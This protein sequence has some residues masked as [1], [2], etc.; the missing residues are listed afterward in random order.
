MRVPI[1][2]ANPIKKRL[3][4]LEEKINKVKEP[5]KIHPKPVHSKKSQPEF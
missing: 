4:K 5:K 1:F 3:R 2:K